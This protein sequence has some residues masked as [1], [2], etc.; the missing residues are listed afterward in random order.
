ME[1]RQQMFTVKTKLNFASNIQ[2]VN[3][4]T[5]KKNKFV[6]KKTSKKKKQNTVI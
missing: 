1:A 2:A 3:I 6:N 4:Y 5:Q